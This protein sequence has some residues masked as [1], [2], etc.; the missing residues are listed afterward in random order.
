MLEI[1]CLFDIAG[2]LVYNFNEFLALWFQ[3]FSVIQL[4]EASATYEKIFKSFMVKGRLVRIINALKLADSSGYW[5]I[6]LT[7][8]Q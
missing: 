6:I 8:N 7:K 3:T 2:C 1:P 5:G 4:S